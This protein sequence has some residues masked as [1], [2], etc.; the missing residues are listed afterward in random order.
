MSPCT[1]FQTAIVQFLCGV[2][3]LQCH[4]T[5][6]LSLKHCGVNVYWPEAWT[7]TVTNRT[8]VE[9]LQHE[10]GLGPNGELS[11]AHLQRVTVHCGSTQIF[12]G[13]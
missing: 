9:E 11:A 3:Q 12:L 5:H 6:E 13:K 7:A 2:S 4:K 8:Q 1:T 10:V